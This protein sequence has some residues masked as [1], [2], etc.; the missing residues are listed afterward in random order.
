MKNEKKLKIL[1][2]ITNFIVFYAIL[3]ACFNNLYTTN[4]LLY[5]LRILGI[6]TALGLIIYVLILSRFNKIIFR[7]S[8]SIIITFIIC[9][10]FAAFINFPLTKLLIAILIIFIV[11][12]VEKK[13]KIEKINIINELIYIGNF[14][15]AAII[16]VITTIYTHI[17][18]FIFLVY[19]LNYI[20]NK[21]ICNKNLK[22]FFAFSS[23]I[24]F[25]IIIIF[26]GIL[27]T[28]SV[29]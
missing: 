28:K 29:Y 18:F 23:I 3:I 6:L 1:M 24:I 26:F 8:L 11:Y 5:T 21:L 10:T 12:I 4:N 14:T 22:I 27:I 9:L 15:L 20:L 17:P 19:I 7:T 25:F 16:S 13:F 2:H